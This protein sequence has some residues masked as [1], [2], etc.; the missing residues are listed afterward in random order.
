MP[1][2]IE[3]SPA[4]DTHRP[5]RGT[6]ALAAVL[7]TLAT[8]C[9]K[10]SPT[11]PTDTSST[12]TVATPTV[13]EDF[14]GTLPVGGS[15]FYSFTVEQNG[16]VN[17]TLTSVGGTGVPSTVWLGLGIGVPDAEDCTTS[18]AVNTQSGSSVQ[19][20]GTYA[21]GI[22]CARVADIGNLAAPASFAVTIAHP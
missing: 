20:T 4:S 22:Y 18:S 8:A 6:L 14:V 15:R 10:D 7:M 2:P 19:V 21:P 9:N 5:H 12:S 11:S 3:S 13:T 16:T 17:V 1:N